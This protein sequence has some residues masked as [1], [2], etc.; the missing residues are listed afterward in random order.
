MDTSQR[1][2]RL[3]RLRRA[4]EQDDRTINEQ[5]QNTAADEEATHIQSENDDHKRK[6]ESLSA[7]EQPPIKKPMAF[8]PNFT[9]IAPLAFHLERYRHTGLRASRLSTSDILGHPKKKVSPPM[10]PTNAAHSG[11]VKVISTSSR[12][13]PEPDG[14]CISQSYTLYSGLAKEKEKNASPPCSIT[15]SPERSPPP[16]STES[17]SLKAASPKSYIVGHGEAPASTAR[18][19]LAIDLYTQPSTQRPTP[20]KGY[21]RRSRP[22]SPVRHAFDRPQ[23]DS[24]QSILASESFTSD[25]PSTLSEAPSTPTPPPP[26][27]ASLSNLPQGSASK[28]ITPI[29]VAVS[30]SSSTPFDLTLEAGSDDEKKPNISINPKTRSS[31]SSPSAIAGLPDYLQQYTKWF[32]L[33]ELEKA[34]DLRTELE[35]YQAADYVEILRSVS[36]S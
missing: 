21:R 25:V 24:G 16:P 4:N 15:S 12:R 35:V 2:D 27:E 7:P 20:Q 29:Q 1:V 5:E 19:T 13:P 22:L 10:R 9:T 26:E 34:H 32:K 6:A 18:D 14:S 11:P 30:G 17:L 3:V 28:P 36:A 33:G 23:A 8:I 31:E